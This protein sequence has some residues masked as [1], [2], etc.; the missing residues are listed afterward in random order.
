V[1][2]VRVRG[3]LLAALVGRATVKRDSPEANVCLSPD[4]YL[5]GRVFSRLQEHGV[6]PARAAAVAG[7]VAARS[8]AKR[9][10]AYQRFLAGVDEETALAVDRAQRIPGQMSIDEALAEGRD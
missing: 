10:I 8:R 5:A 6:D 1:A 3:P 9:D 4:A 7:K 2:A